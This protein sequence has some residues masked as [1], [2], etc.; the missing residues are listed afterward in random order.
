MV[1][2]GQ[3]VLTPCPIVDYQHFHILVIPQTRQEFRRNEEILTGI[4]TTSHF[5]QLIM[6]IPFG[7]LIHALYTRPIRKWK[8]EYNR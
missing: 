7:S 2:G 1:T 6:H 4:G 3:G 5:D 8:V